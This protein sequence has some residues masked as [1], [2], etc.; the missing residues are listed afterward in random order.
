MVHV[1]LYTATTTHDIKRQDIKRLAEECVNRMSVCD[2]AM[3]TSL[4]KVAYIYKSERH[5]ILTLDIIETKLE[6]FISKYL[7]RLMLIG[8]FLEINRVKFHSI[9]AQLP[10]QL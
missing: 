10:L 2:E 8:E 7:Q 6:N 5:N 3:H 4:D 9:E 1:S